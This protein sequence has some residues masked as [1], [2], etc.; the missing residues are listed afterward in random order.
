MR[1]RYVLIVLIA[2]AFTSIFIGAHSLTPLDLLNLNDL[3]VQILLISRLPRLASLLLA[4]MSMGICGLIMQQLTQN[5][6]VSPTTAGTLDSA[7]LGVLVSMLLFTNAQPLLKTTIAF[8]FALLGTFF[9]IQMLERI[10]FKDAI[11][12]PLA[13]LMFGAVI[14]SLSTFLGLQFD[15]MQNVS[16]WLMG[17]FSTIISGRYELLYVNVPLMIIAYMYASRFTIAGLG[18]EAATNLGLH[19]KSIMRLGLAIVA[20]ITAT[21]ILTVGSI[22]FLGLL[23]PNIVSI[24]RGDHLRNTLPL[25]ALVG[26]I[27]VLACDILGRLIIYPYEIPISFTVGFLGS[28]VFVFL[29]MR[30]TSYG[31]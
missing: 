11:F 17:D 22:P 28:G 1:T 21:N 5:R 14:N 12:V 29:L 26:G 30:R 20:M 19:Y 15:L 24:Y 23:V 25:T 2:L 18:E 10:K 8:V 6:F 16:A 31:Y 7:R 13:G 3:K 27:I 9:F 4:G